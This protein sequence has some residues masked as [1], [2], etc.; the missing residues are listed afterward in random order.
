MTYFVG[1]LVTTVPG[2]WIVGKL[3]QLLLSSGNY[4]PDGLIAVKGDEAARI[5]SNNPA[6]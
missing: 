1:M 4:V 6:G 2:K 3:E 5:V